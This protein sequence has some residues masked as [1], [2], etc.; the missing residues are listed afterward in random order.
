M[1]LSI[2]I[3]AAGQGTR[4]KSELPK[5]LQPL[6]GRPLLEHVID[7]SEILGADEVYVVYGFG[8]EQVK[9][10]LGH[11]DVN[12]VLQE[13]Q[14]GTGHAVMQAI[15][16]IPEDHTVLVL[17]GDV[18]LVNPDTLQCL[19]APAYGRCLALLSVEQQDPTG[20]GRIV[21]DG[22]GNVLQI[23]EEKDANEAEL[24]IAEVNTGLL[25]AS[26]GLLRKWLNELDNN[27][28]Q[29]EY[30]LT[31]VVASAVRD[32]VPV[33]GV[34]AAS[35]D[36]V[37]GVNDKLQLSQVETAFRLQQGHTLME[38]GVTIADPARL[39]VRGT[40]SHGRDVFIDVNVVLEGRIELGDR[41]HIGPN[42]CISN[43]RIGAGTRILPN[44]VID[45]A[46]IGPRCVIGPFARIRPETRLE[47]AVKVGNFVEIKKSEVATGSKVNHLTYVGDTTIGKNV[48][49]GAGT[50]TCNYDGANKHRTEI[51]DGAFIGS[52]V[53]L[54]APVRIGPNATIG[55]G[56]T[57]TR[58]APSEALTLARS[59]QIT[60][61]GWERPQKETD[62]GQDGQAESTEEAGAKKKKSKVRTSR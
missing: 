8:G 3:L 59:E 9:A 7:S 40:V 13:E 27:N 30:Y 19:L 47:E 36:E 35:A 12:W 32:G 26:A 57:I 6:A 50:I 53:Q 42:V 18:P 43:S 58:H 33:E 22:A 15:P 20:Y 41:V 17:Y 55:A 46:E 25:A 61:E 62:A 2:V 23:V 56:S 4:M 11:R 16:D 29:G 37:L 44:S 51:E 14:L 21:R 52:G 48:N 10:A 1:P 28:A 5:V 24:A 31:D 45:E 49:V 39:D 54:V 34:K 38:N 60:V